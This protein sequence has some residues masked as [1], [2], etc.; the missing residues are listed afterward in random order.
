[1]QEIWKTNLVSIGESVGSY[2][3][4]KDDDTPLGKA[5]FIVLDIITLIVFFSLVFNIVGLWRRSR[6]HRNFDLA[7]F[8][9][10]TMLTLLCKNAY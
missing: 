6:F 7:F 9:F 10:F 2:S 3:F 4:Y 8:Y 5:A 1:M